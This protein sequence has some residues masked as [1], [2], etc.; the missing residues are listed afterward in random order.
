MKTLAFLS[1][2]LLTATLCLAAEKKITPGPKGGKL[3]E[4]SSPRAEFFIEKDNRVVV[5]FYDDKLNPVPVTSQVV[6][7]TAEPVSGKVKVELEKKDGTLV[8]KEP[9]PKGEGY[10][11]VVQVQ[12]TANAKPQNFRL[13]LDLH[14]CGECKRGEYACICGH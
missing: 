1:T 12:A 10:S 14:V 7:I 13:K 5:T 4:N 2:V 6:A 11:I 8:S 9:L 3:L